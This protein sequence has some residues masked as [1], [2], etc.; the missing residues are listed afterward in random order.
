MA[1]QVADGVKRFNR[2]VLQVDGIAGSEWASTSKLRQLGLALSLAWRCVIAYAI[3]SPLRMV[4]WQVTPLQATLQ[5]C[6]AAMHFD[7]V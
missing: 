7:E 4:R 2:F 3:C 5:L 1:G 6:A